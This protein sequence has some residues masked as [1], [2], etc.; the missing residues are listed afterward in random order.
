MKLSD[1]LEA[2]HSTAPA[3]RYTVDDFVVAG[4]RRKRRRNAGWAVA[5]VVAVA[6]AVGIPQVLL[7]HDDAGPLP[8]T[9]APP[10]R[11]LN[12]LFESYTVKG[13][14]QDL[15]LT[16][17][18]PEWVGV[19]NQNTY[20]VR[21]TPRNRMPKRVG[22]LTVFRT[23]FDASRNWADATVTATEPI[24]GRPAFFAVP[25]RPAADGPEVPDRLLIWQYADEP[26]LHRV[27]DMGRRCAEAFLKHGRVRLS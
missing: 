18:D 7:R 15:T 27:Y 4:R 1:L 23:G 10:T 2:A 11:P 8:A 17:G 24:G 14:E 6:V 5:A 21:A 9:P 22:D 19:N 3:A 16:V 25:S 26:S 12:Y 20:I 13:Q